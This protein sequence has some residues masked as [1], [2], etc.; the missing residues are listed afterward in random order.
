MDRDG[1]EQH[2]KMES[3]PSGIER[4]LELLTYFRSYMQDNLIKT[5]TAPLDRDEL[6]RLPFPRQ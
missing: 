2:Y 1:L 4:K 6:I 3:Y 5:G